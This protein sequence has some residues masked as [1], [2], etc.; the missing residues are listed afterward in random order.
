[1]TIVT[2]PAGAQISYRVT[3]VLLGAVVLIPVFVVSAAIGS[4]DLPCWRR[5]SA[6][7][8]VTRC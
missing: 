8:L 3:R 4:P 5:G 2:L 1:M 6:C 7:K